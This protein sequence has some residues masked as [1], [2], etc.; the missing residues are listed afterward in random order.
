M[1]CRKKMESKAPPPVLFFIKSL[2]LSLNRKFNALKGFGGESS[3]FWR[4]G[5][6]KRY[7]R[8]YVAFCVLQPLVFPAIFCIGFLNPPCYETPKN[9]NKRKNEQKKERKQAY[10]I[11]LLMSPE[12]RWIALD[13]FPRDSPC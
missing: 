3:C 6:Q 12:P 4:S 9:A 13:F 7:A 1:P 5:L 11:F 8:T 10:N 2:G